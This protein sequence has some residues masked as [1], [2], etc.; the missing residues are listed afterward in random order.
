MHYRREQTFDK[1]E[2]RSKMTFFGE[3][4]LRKAIR[5]YL[6]HDHQEGIH[7]GMGNQIIKPSALIGQARGDVECHRR[8]GGL[9]RY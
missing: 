8:L 3:R 2:A 4:S 1:G 7:Q 6:A 5:S 9:L